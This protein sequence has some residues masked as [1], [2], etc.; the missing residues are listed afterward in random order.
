M[1]IQGLTSS[2]VVPAG[3]CTVPEHPPQ[4]WAHLQLPHSALPFLSLWRHRIAPAH[5]AARANCTHNASNSTIKTTFCVCNNDDDDGDVDDGDDTVGGGDG[6]C[7]VTAVQSHTSLVCCSGCVVGVADERA[8]LRACLW[9]GVAV[10]AAV[11]GGGGPD[12]LRREPEYP[13]ARLRAPHAPQHLPDLLPGGLLGLVDGRLDLQGTCTPSYLPKRHINLT[14][15]RP[16]AISTRL[17]DLAPAARS[18][19]TVFVSALWSGLSARQHAAPS[20]GRRQPP[21]VDDGRRRPCAVP[22]GPHARD[23]P[24]R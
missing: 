8:V 14:P 22:G 20:R 13:H 3:V 5:M 6:H 9:G 1:P 16:I 23:F 12:L 19:L 18:T 17:P 24:R 11:S 2:L 4:A 21:H 15:Y 10:H 7:A